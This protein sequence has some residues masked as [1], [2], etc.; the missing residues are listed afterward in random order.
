[1]A[2]K[3]R[4]SHKEAKQPDEFITLTNQAMAWGRAHQQTVIWSAIAVAVLIAALGIAT[5]YR[6]AQRRDANADLA[7]AVAKIQ[8]NDLAGAITD[9][10]TVTE[11]WSGTEV[12]RI[13]TLMAANTALRLGDP[14]KALSALASIP[15]SSLPAYL[16]QQMLLAWGTALEDKEQWADAATKYRA[17]AAIAGPYTGTAIVAEARTTELAGDK[18]KARTLYRQA[19]EQFPDLPGREVLT[20]KI[21]AS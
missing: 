4:L 8:S 10:N 6:S 9:L 13:A 21:S 20:S 12:A 19:Y 16:Q 5:A 18:E 17:A 1:M 7:Q 15:S 3:A 2:E 11:R 14:D